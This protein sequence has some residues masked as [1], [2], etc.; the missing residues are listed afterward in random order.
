M[1]SIF[2][3]GDDLAVDLER[4][5]AGPAE[6]AHVVEGE[7]ADAE[8][9]IFE[10]ELDRVLAGRQR[11]GAFPLDPLQVDQVPQEHRLA[12]EQI[13][14]IAGEAPARGQDHALGTAL[15]HVDVGGDGVGAVEQ[16]RRV[17]LRQADHRMGVDELACG[18]R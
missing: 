8:A 1:R 11:V 2:F 4:A 17:A 12:L 10:V 18:R 9:V 6:T 16:Q 13:E 14:A 3:G 5:G 15:G 7:R